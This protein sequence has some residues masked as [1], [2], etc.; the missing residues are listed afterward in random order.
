MEPS[1]SAIKG[2]DG[3][4]GRHRRAARCSRA[5]RGTP[6][7]P[8]HPRTSAGKSAVFGEQLCYWETTP[9]PVLARAAGASKRAPAVDAMLRRWIGEFAAFLDETVELAENADTEGVERTA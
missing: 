5:G 9:A 8:P 3:V 1:G 2:S 6:G 7:I 4:A